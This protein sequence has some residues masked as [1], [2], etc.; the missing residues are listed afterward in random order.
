[1]TQDRPRHPFYWCLNLSLTAVL[2]AA[3]SMSGAKAETPRIGVANPVLGPLVDVT[4]KSGESTKGQ[5]LSFNGGN[6]EL[7]LD[8][9]SVITRDGV[10]VVSVR[11][12]VP[13]KPLTGPDKNRGL[14]AQE[15]GL[16]LL[17][18]EHMREWRF[19]DNPPKIPL[20]NQKQ[21]LVPLT[22]AERVEHFKLLKKADVHITALK[23]EIPGS[24]SEEEARAMLHEL[25]RY[26]FLSGYT[27]Q[28]IKTNLKLVSD[29]IK[30]ENIKKAILAGTGIEGLFKTIETKHKGL[31]AFEKANEPRA[32]ATGTPAPQPAVRPST[33]N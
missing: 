14:S 27:P 3:I 32:P 13:E 21:A 30:D 28:D 2:L 10:S 11:F 33:G 22:D 29:G 8:N 9:G 19:R 5:L 17:E 18:I 20:P 4:L 16:S 1:M 6:L 7:K 15:T 25:G 26:Y 31:K 23:N 12:I 24:A